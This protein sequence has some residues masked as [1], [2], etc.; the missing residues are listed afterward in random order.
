MKVKFTNPTNSNEVLFGNITGKTGRMF[1]ILRET[2]VGKIY[3]VNPND[4]YNFGF[5]LSAK[6]EEKYAAKLDE[7]IDEDGNFIEK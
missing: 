6:G 1:T 2:G 7:M 5:I 4:D 3:M